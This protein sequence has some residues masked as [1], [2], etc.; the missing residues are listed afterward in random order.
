MSR[1]QLTLLAMA[2]LVG[3]AHAD[4]KEFPLVWVCLGITLAGIAVS[5]YV[6]YRRPDELHIANMEE[7]SNGPQERSPNVLD[8]SL[9]R[10]RNCTNE[11]RV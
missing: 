4:G 1:I 2:A 8:D 7:E 11:D 5:L 9:P 10:D 6:A 3:A